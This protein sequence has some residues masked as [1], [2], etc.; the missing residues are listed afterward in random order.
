M[1]IEDL[2]KLQQQ[3]RKYNQEYYDGKSTAIDIVAT[4]VEEK[5]KT[6]GNH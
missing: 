5:L 1:D 2:I 3:L 6:N 4:N